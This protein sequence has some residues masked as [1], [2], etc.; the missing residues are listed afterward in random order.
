[1]AGRW[2]AVAGRRTPLWWFSAEGLWVLRR[3]PRR[4]LL[5][6]APLINGGSVDIPVQKRGQGRCTSASAAVA[7]VSRAAPHRVSYGAVSTVSVEQ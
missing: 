1:M 6:R 4:A 3:D 7:A 2:T 5:R